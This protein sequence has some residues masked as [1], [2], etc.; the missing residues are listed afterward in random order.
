MGQLFDRVLRPKT[1]RRRRGGRAHFPA[2]KGPKNRN[3]KLSATKLIL[4]QQSMDKSLLRSH[5][6]FQP[7]WLKMAKKCMPIYGIIVIFGDFLAYL[8]PN[9]FD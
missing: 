1:V 6:K 4:H 9:L 8:R 5:K 3:R 7:D 2:K